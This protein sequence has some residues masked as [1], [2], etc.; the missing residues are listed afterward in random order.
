[1]MYMTW[2]TVSVRV[3]Y[4]CVGGTMVVYV[5]CGIGMRDSLHSCTTCARWTQAVRY[6]RYCMGMIEWL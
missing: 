5:V 4:I 2:C 6:S 1:M 3:G